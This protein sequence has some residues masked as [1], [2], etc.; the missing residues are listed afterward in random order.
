MR[1]GSFHADQRDAAR[2]GA[3]SGTSLVQ[4]RPELG[5]IRVLPDDHGQQVRDHR[6][7]PT[8]PIPRPAP[9]PPT[10]RA[11]PA[12]PPPGRPLRMRVPITGGLR[13]WGPPMWSRYRGP[14]HHLRR[15]LR[16]PLQTASRRAASWPGYAVASRGPP[17]STSRSSGS[18]SSYSRWRPGWVSL[19]TPWPGCCSPSRARPRTSFLGPSATGG[20]SVWSSPSSPLSSPSRWWRRHGIS[21]TSGRSVGPCSSAAA[22]VIL[23]RR[24]ASE[25][26]RVWINDDLLPILRTGTDRQGRWMIVGRV[27]VGFVLAAAGLFALVLGHRSAPRCAPSSGRCWSSRPWWSSSG[28]GG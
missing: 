19:S 21:P 25:K 3:V 26:E 5:Q 16:G 10:L 7:S 13:H 14:G 8:P 4:P 20:A 28:R 1:S 15:R 12:G 17:A 27:A 18:P 2:S 11:P 22:V 24:N 6:I 9:E 23:I